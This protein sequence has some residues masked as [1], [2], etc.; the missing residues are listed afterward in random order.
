[1]ASLSFFE[2]ERRP[3][4]LALLPADALRP[5][6][7]QNRRRNSSHRQGRLAGFRLSAWCSE[8]IVEDSGACGSK[9]PKEN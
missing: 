3:P 7:A 2:V 9:G 5:A 6:E 8:Q 4:F 1:M